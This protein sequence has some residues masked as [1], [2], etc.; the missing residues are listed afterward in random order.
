M[1]DLTG[2]P[3]AGIFCDAGCAAFDVT[4]VTAPLADGTVV[5]RIEK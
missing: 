3:S 4:W 2:A 5:N 1:E